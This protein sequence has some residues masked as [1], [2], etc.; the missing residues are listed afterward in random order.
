MVQLA[1]QIVAVFAAGCRTGPVQMQQPLGFQSIFCVRSA[2][3]DHTVRGALFLSPRLKGAGIGNS[4][5]FSRPVVRAELGNPQDKRRIR[6]TY[7]RSSARVATRPE[8]QASP[9]HI[10]HYPEQL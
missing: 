3:F 1:L 7:L 5:T 8:S 9:H 10:F 4:G 2:S 6:Q